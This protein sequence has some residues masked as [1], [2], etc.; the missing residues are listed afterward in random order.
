MSMQSRWYL[1]VSPDLLRELALLT[2]HGGPLRWKKKC[3]R[4]AVTGKFSAPPPPRGARESSAERRLED[5]GPFSDNAERVPISENG[6]STGTDA[7]PEGTDPLLWELG[8]LRKV[9]QG[10]LATAAS[11]RNL[12]ATEALPSAQVREELE[13]KLNELA[14]RIRQ[15]EAAAPKCPRCG[16][17]LPH[18]MQ[19]EEEEPKPDG[20]GVQ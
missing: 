14:E 11:T 3:P 1:R 9:A 5:C 19:V 10:A 17:A 4:C 16:Q 2:R 20:P 7:P 12:S 8:Q 13:R 18:G 6:R 15:A